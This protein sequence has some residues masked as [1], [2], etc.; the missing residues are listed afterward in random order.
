MLFL[1]KAQKVKSK[2]LKVKIKKFKSQKTANCLLLSAYYLLPTAH[3][4][5]P[6]HQKF[7]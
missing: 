6:R 5:L 3:W 4:P 7:H 1:G 2:K